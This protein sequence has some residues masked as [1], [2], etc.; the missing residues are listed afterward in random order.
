MNT[1]AHGFCSKAHY[2]KAFAHLQQQ[3]GSAFTV[4][5]FSD[6]LEW[7]KQEMNFSNAVFVDNSRSDL[8]NID[9]FLMS[10]CK[11]HIIANSTYSWWAAWLNPSKEKKVLAPEWWTNEHKTCEIDLSFDGMQIIE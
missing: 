5:V 11:H 9:L 2:E 7:V 6:D 1:T 3:I 10:A 4:F 8:K